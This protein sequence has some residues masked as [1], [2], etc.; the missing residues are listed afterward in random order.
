[1]LQS[2]VVK[3]KLVAER[4]RVRDYGSVIMVVNAV[5]SSVEE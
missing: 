4:W 1:M 5:G 3:P 2:L